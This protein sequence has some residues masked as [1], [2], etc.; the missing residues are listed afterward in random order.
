MYG[1]DFEV[2]GYQR[3]DAEVPA[4]DLVKA[5][6]IVGECLK[7]ARGDLIKAELARL[8]VST[9]SRAELDDD[10]AM[11]FQVLAEECANYPPDVVV[12]ALRGW[13]RSETFYPSL[14][15]IRDRLQRGVRRRRSLLA[16]ITMGR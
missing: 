1:Y 4:E 9:K 6:G 11:G 3:V 14:A 13:A 16:A 12:W 15:E 8:R 10:L 7:G 2:I 5:K